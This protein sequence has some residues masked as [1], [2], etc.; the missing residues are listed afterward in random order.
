VTVTIG[1]T[2]G[3]TRGR[4]NRGGSVEIEFADVGVERDRT[5]I[6]SSGPRRLAQQLTQIASI[7]VSLA[8]PGIELNGLIEIGARGGKAIE[9]KA[10]NAAMVI[11]F[12]ASWNGFYGAG[13][14]GF[15]MGTKVGCTVSACE[16]SAIAPSNSP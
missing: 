15:G 3:R 4:R 2:R 1:R 12:S 6:V 7:V 8:K 9:I 10:G 16:K 13:E 5:V 11:G 14:I